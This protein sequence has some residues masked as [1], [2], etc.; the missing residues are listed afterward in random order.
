MSTHDSTRLHNIP[1][2]QANATLAVSATTNRTS[3]PCILNR[4]ARTNHQSPHQKCATTHKTTRTHRPSWTSSIQADSQI[5]KPSSAFSPISSH[6]HRR[7]THAQ[8]PVENARTAHGTFRS[9]AKS[10]NS[11]SRTGILISSPMEP[12]DIALR[13]RVWQSL[14]RLIF[15]GLV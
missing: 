8:Y 5:S 4:A 14:S 1:R 3:E 2:L 13:C 6:S 10:T 9:S 11:S 12:M 15:V 7:L